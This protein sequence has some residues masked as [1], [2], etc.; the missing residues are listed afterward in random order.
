MPQFITQLMISIIIEHVRKGLTLHMDD[1]R[2]FLHDVPTHTLR[3][4]TP[5]DYH[6]IMT[7]PFQGCTVIS[8]AKKGIQTRQNSI[9]ET[10]LGVRAYGDVIV[11]PL[12]V[13]MIFPNYKL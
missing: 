7:P 12:P 9:A 13:D 3:G 1:R 2:V 11:T 5:Y 8:H 4:C 10:L 6:Y